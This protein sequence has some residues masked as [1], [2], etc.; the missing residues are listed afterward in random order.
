MLINVDCFNQI[1]NIRWFGDFF[2]AKISN[3]KTRT[4]YHYY[5]RW[6]ITGCRWLEIIECKDV[7]I[8]DQILSF[9]LFFLFLSF[10]FPSYE[11]LGFHCKKDILRS[12]FLFVE[13][14]YFELKLYWIKAFYI[15]VY[16]HEV[17]KEDLLQ[18]VLD[19]TWY[20]LKLQDLLI[21]KIGFK[22]SVKIVEYAI[23]LYGY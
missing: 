18:L 13:Y 2:I 5:H 6:Y 8:L 12:L 23:V 19:C 9:F 3:S 17:S 1:S 7:L 20:R 11:S 15:S 10:C 16:S 21:S 14:M 4:S 22:I